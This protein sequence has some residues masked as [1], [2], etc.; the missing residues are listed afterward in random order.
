M[1]QDAYRSIEHQQVAVIP[2]WIAGHADPGSMAQL[3]RA[4]TRWLAKQTPERNQRVGYARN[5]VMTLAKPI[6]EEDFA[7]KQARRT[8]V[9]AAE[10]NGIKVT[11]FTDVAAERA[12]AETARIE[13]IKEAKNI[14][15]AARIAA[16]PE[17]IVEAW[18]LR[19]IQHRNWSEMS[20]AEWVATLPEDEQTIIIERRLFAQNVARNRVDKFKCTT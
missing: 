6:S 18:G 11:A 17:R 20:R 1:R 8:A 16:L 14:E 13:K 15:I 4:L 10:R 7:I 3:D 19:K 5:R 9:R 2:Q 12:K